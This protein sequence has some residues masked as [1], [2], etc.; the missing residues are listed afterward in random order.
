MEKQFLE[1]G[2]KRVW[3]FAQYEWVNDVRGQ[4]TSASFPTKLVLA[5][6]AFAV[7]FSGG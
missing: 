1:E 5:S 2:K 4:P 7:Q 3:P 6:G